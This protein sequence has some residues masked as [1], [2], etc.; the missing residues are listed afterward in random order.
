MDI[1]GIVLGSFL[2][3][4]LQVLFDKLTSSTLNYAQREGI[5]KTLP[6][7]WKEMLLTIKAVMADAEDKQLNGNRQ[8]KLWLDSV[9]DLAYD[10]EDLLDEF[11]I[12]VA[13][14]ESKAESSTSRGLG[15][16]K[17]PVFG[18]RHL[19]LSETKVQDIN[20]KLEVIVTRKAHLNL[21]ENVIDRSNYTSKRDP[22]T[23]LPEPRFFGR[24][25]EEAQMLKLLFN[26]VEN[27][28][29]TLRIV[30]IVGMGGIGKTALAKRLYNNA[31][32]NGCF[33]RKAWVCVSDVFDIFNITKNI[34]HSITDKSWENEDFNGLQVSL[35]DSL[36]G[37]KFLVVLDDIWN[38]NYQRWTDL[39]R[40]FEV[41]ARGSRIIITTRNLDVA[42]ITGGSPY[43][44][45]ELSLD[46]CI[47]L[48]AFHALQKTNFESH[49]EF[50]TIGKKIAE[51]CKGLPLAAKM[52][53]GALR[54]KKNPDEWKD[55]LNKLT[56][57]LPT[58]ENEVLC[59]LKLSYVH[60]PSYLKRCFSY[61]AVFPKDYE[62]E[63]DELVLLW[64]AEGFL[65]GH[66][67]KENK[68]R[69]GRNYFDE[70]VSRSF[71][72]QSS[73]HT[74]KFSMHDMLNDL[75]KSIEGG[76]CSSFGESQPVVNED[77]ASMKR[78]RYASFISS[79]FVTSKC[80]RAYHGLKVLR[81]LIL[82]CV[83][84]S[85]RSNKFFISNKALNDLLTNLKYLRVFSLCHCDIKEVPNC[86]GELK[87]LR[88]LNFSDTY[89]KRLPEP[90]GGLCKLQA[91]I[92]RGCHR[93]SKLPED[94]A[95]LV[96]LQYLDIR[97]TGS[98][99]KMP[100][101]ISNLK[102]LTI[103]SK[104]VVGTEKGLQLKELNNL[105]HLQGELF[106]SN[107]Q[108]VED[109][110][111][112]VDANLLGKQGLR[113][114][115]LHWDK[116]F[117][118]LRNDK[119]KSGVLESLRP[120]IDI[121]NL[122]IL[123]YGGTIF[124]SWLDGSSYSRMVSLCLWDCPYVTSLPSLGQLP[125]LRE[126]SL[127]GLNA[128]RIIGSNFYGGDRPFLSLITL[129]FKEMLAWKD[130]SPY[131]GGP[132]EEV[133]FSCLQHLVVQSCPSLVGTLPSQL[134][135]LIKLEIH[136]CQQLN[137]SISELCLPSLDELYLKDCSKEILRRLV[138]LTSLTILKIKSI[139]ELV[140]FDHGFMSYMGNLKKLYIGQCDKLTFLW[141]DGDE[142]R[143]LT[144][145]Q[146]LVIKKCP[147]FISFVVGGGE[148]E[149]S[150]NLKRME[151]VDCTSLEKLPSKMHTLRRLVITNCPK[152]MEL[153][154][155]QDDFSS[156][157][158]ISQ[159]ESLEVSAYNSPI[160]FSFANGR[161]APVK[162]LSINYCKGVESLEGITI[163]SL[164]RIRIEGCENMGSLPQCLHTLSHL[165]QLH[166]C[167]CPAL[168]IEDFPPLPITL[169]SLNLSNCSKIKSI[170]NC[171]IAN[172][173][174]LTKLVIWRCL[175]LEIE[176][177]PP[178]P[179]TLQSLTLWA[180]SMIKS[181]PNQWH[182]LTSLQELIICYCENIKCFPKG[183]LPPK[184]RVLRI[185]GLV[186]L[187]QP[188][189]EWGL[190]LL[191]SLERLSV[192][193][194]RGGEGENEWFPSKDEDAWS[195]FPSSLIGLRIYDLRNAERLSSGLRNR[196]SSLQW[197]LIG[198]CPK[199]RY[200][201]EDGFPPS[202][203]Q[204]LIYSCKILKKQYAKL[205]SDY[206]PLIQ[207]IPEI[208]IDERIR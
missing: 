149:L 104:F 45:K 121:E 180:C 31:E 83:G 169:S 163:E 133:P 152:I 135:R 159:L 116:D 179:L 154:I 198:D 12:K 10:M 134:N 23:S 112:A 110:R 98:L 40:P 4:F 91:L 75:A 87:H 175:A 56:G 156:N 67:I 74:S 62:I 30:P 206:W 25:K 146:E 43:P 36:F 85:R 204:L 145:L 120:H 105:S 82:V 183:G 192:D 184:L 66:K 17:F 127:K 97:D 173:N 94:I 111:D 150:Y 157:N 58:A 122:T 65:D 64:I 26:E 29:A 174:N 202:L 41:G 1:G 71:L 153:N 143:N 106:I 132:K 68:L 176:D 170:A 88:Y 140:S 22:T 79:Q 108:K 168:E 151:L 70:L 103:L 44:L 90:I 53:G 128:V 8:V 69:L 3:S 187:K 100:L 73:V 182:H 38:D 166:I 167:N 101:G 52:L 34:F 191:T 126:L 5:S 137:N 205:T 18:Q 114:L 144:C 50:E 14:V 147:Q 27:S 96:S 72:Q 171:N 136:S 155:L 142:T 46:N 20:G 186:N 131:V 118:M 89:I 123:N 117:G 199:L 178:L 119:H 48:L 200:L 113:K 76:I 24:E 47:S 93:L 55:T 164:E 139:I 33:E 189:R 195:L 61:C 11:A 19:H 9:R 13:Q 28:D 32:V 125:L 21:S 196:L 2:A 59:I 188:V 51:R 42:F 148:I 109:V 207:E 39:L 60:L 177:F 7:E 63:R 158:S 84:S 129:Q 115:F 81:S 92:L 160:S 37:K 99:K 161:V 80:L 193:F 15:K 172:C 185:Q 49:L 86:V 203:Q 78:T 181:L 201:P 208:Y 16:W 190:H 165:T 130:W 95:K 194:D 197:L 107:L 138:N 77:D 54:N 102:N 35:R 6:K 162:A 57:G 141:Q 124:P